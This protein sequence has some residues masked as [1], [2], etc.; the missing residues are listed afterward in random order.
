MSAPTTICYVDG[1][2]VTWDGRTLAFT[3]GLTIDAD[4]SPR[5]YGPNNS[6]LDLTANA[7]HPGNW[8][9][10]VVGDDGKPIVQGPQAPCPGM[11]VSKTSYEHRRFFE[12]DPRRYVDSEK[13]PFVVLPHHLR[14]KVPPIVLGC[15]AK[16]HNTRNGLRCVAVVAD[17][18]PAD[19]LGEGSIALAKALGINAD[20]RHGGTDEAIVDYQIFPGVPAF[21]AGETFNLQAA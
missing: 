3:A 9:G 4:G 11:Y 2:P 5:A 21:V 7:G 10:I 20:A 19:H 18:G 13:V 6:G 15:L 8:W 1:K 12:R 16:V 17:F 14:K